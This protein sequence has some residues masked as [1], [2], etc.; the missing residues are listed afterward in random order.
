MRFSLLLLALLAGC[1]DGASTISQGP[2]PSQVYSF[3]MESG[4]TAAQMAATS[5]AYSEWRAY[6]GLSFPL[7]R[8]QVVTWRP[9][10]PPGDA[11]GITALS[12]PDGRLEWAEVAVQGSAWTGDPAYLR[13]VLLH[14]IGHTLGLEHSGDCGSIMYPGFCGATGIDPTSATQAN[15]NID[16]GWVERR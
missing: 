8:D 6:V 4:F 12:A 1:G 2:A 14:E 11:D 13:L 3:W 5:A 16:A 15:A 9:G 10:N 7:R